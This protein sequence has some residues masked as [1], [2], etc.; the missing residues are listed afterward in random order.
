MRR[1][2]PGLIH[3]ADRGSQ[4]CSTDYQA[5]RR[6]HGILISMF[7]TG[8]CYDNSMV[9]TFFKTLKSGLVWRTVFETRHEAK[10]AISRYIDGFYT[11]S[12]ATSRSTSQARPS[13]REWSP[14]GHFEK[15]RG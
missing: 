11:L 5:A 3:H 13:S 6:K 1:R 14:I 2:A 12:G 9:E 10:Q 8:N 7:G 4:S 15:P